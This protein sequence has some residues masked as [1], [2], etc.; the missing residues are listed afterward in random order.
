MAQLKLVPIPKVSLASLSSVLEQTKFI[1]H[2]EVA[3]EG[4]T[5]S[6]HVN[7]SPKELEIQSLDRSPINCI[8]FCDLSPGV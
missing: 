4:N 7:L 5:S 6:H 1:H 2:L 3:V 8:H